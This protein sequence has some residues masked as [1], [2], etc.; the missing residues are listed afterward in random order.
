MKPYVIAKIGSRQYKLLEGDVLEVEKQ[1]LKPEVLFYFDGKKV[2]VG[3]PVLKNVS[4]KLTVQ[5]EKKSKKVS[6]R[7]FKSKSRYQKN[8]GHRQGIIVVKVGKISAKAKTTVKNSAVKK[9]A[10]K[11]AVVKAKKAP[12]KKK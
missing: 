5:E 6:V 4:V 12:A 10:T 8:K 3:T 7:R 9:P 2:E 1:D 11:K